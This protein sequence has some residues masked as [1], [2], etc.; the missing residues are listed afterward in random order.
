MWAK[1]RRWPRG[2]PGP[3]RTARAGVL[4][5]VSL[6]CVKKK[7]KKNKQKNSL[8]PK[9]KPKPRSLF[10]TCPNPCVSYSERWA[11]QGRWFTDM[12]GSP[13]RRG[14]APG[15]PMPPG[16]CVAW[17]GSRALAALLPQVCPELQKWP[18]PLPGATSAFCSPPM[19]RTCAY[20]HIKGPCIRALCRPCWGMRGGHGLVPTVR[21]RAGHTLA[22]GPGLC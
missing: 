5:I 22:G 17:A 18:S 14:L 15:S 9:P 10:C 19:E 8:E 11:G 6:F 20:V 12:R 16:A 2:G 3:C 4:C 13:S 1:S 7:G 21:D